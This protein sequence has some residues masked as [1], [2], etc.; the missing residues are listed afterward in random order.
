MA[1]LTEKEST[2]AM[3]A[4]RQIMLRFGSTRGLN[5]ALQLAFLYGV[6]RID[7]ANTVYYASLGALT[8]LLVLLSFHKKPHIDRQA[9]GEIPPAP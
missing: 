9:T 6:S 5:Q 8:S 2:T 1:G 4:L 7:E 3:E